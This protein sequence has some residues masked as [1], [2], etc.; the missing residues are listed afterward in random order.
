MALYAIGDLHLSL[1]KDKPMDIFGDKWQNHAEKIK[2]GFASL[3]A[4]DT[5]V[6]CGAIIVGILEEYLVS[7]F[8]GL[9]KATCSFVILH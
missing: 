5:C 1:G 3:G 2:E 8:R 7:D 4:G 6:I 9:V